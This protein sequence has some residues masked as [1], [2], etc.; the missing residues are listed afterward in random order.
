MIRLHDLRHT[1]ATLLLADGVPVKVIS[2][3]LSNANATIP[4]TGHQHVHPG[5]GRQAAS[6]VMQAGPRSFRI[7]SE[8]RTHSHANRRELG[9][10][11]CG[12]SRHGLS[13]KLHRRVSAAS[14]AGERR[15]SPGAVVPAWWPTSRVPPRAEPRHRLHRRHRSQGGLR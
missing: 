7:P 3:R 9:V 10:D 12:I 13:A 11:V 5:M 15:F 14:A 6:S 4:L 1:D 2:E 8:L